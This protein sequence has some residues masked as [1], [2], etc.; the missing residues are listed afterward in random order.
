MNPLKAHHIAIVFAVL[1]CG[2]YPAFAATSAK[3]H[4]SATVLPFV[5]FNAAQH[6]ATY[7][8]SSEDLRR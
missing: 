6:V 8:V 7:Q 5:S 4:V 2:T 3:I 1:L